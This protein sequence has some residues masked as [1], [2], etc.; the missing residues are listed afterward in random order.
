ML[1]IHFSSED[2]ARTTI[3]ATADPLWEILLSLHMLQSREGELVYG[4]W[5]RQARANLPAVVRLMLELAPPTGYSPDFLTPPGGR[6]D[7]D[8]ALDA[9][10]STPRRRIRADLTYLA[11][12]Q[13]TTSWTRRLARADRGT[14]RLLGDAARSYH[15]TAI[16]P[17]WSPMR[18]LVAADRTRRGEQLVSAGVDGLLSDLHPRSRWDSPV[19]QIMDFA[20][21]DVHLEGRGLTL[22]PSYF[23]WQAPTKLRD[24]DLP[25]VLVYPIAH[26]P[27]ELD[28]ARSTDQP[29]LAALV[30]LLGRTRATALDVLTTARTT[31]QLATACRISIATASHHAAV[32]REASLI[33]SRR[34]GG[35]VV[36]EVTTL[37]AHL[38]EHAD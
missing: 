26:R 38:L 5:R 19:L 7:L 31:S 29:R 24:R 17:F 15:D 34:V 14:M 6:A 13:A 11:S 16:A 4:R 10:L 30:A 28:P 25:P 33:S 36:H 1:R 23:C 3:A 8:E 22:V 20:D 21:T 9:M 35:S 37:G 27:G 12:R 2:F 32:L 18:K